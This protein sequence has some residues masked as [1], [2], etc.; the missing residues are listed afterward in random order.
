MMET[1]TRRTFR[2][3][4]RLDRLTNRIFLEPKEIPTLIDRM[5]SDKRQ[6]DLAWLKKDKGQNR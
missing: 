6:S 2:P 4:F 5:K 3:I 1:V